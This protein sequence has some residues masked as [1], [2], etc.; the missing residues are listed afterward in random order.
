MQNRW[1]SYYDAAKDNPPRPTLL[2]A[3]DAWSG[4]PGFALDLGCGA[5]RDTLT[6]LA[7]G[8]RVHA[9]D[10]EQDAFAR[11]ERSVPAK[12][13]VRLTWALRQFEGIDLPKA[14]LA[15]ASFSLPFCHPGM[16][17]R[18][19]QSL[20]SALYPGG[21]FAGHLF[22]DRDSWSGRAE[23]TILSRLE[24]ARLL[25]GWDVIEL[26]ETEWDGETALGQPKHW[27]LFEIVARRPD[28]EGRLLEGCQ[29]DRP[30]RR[31]ATATPAD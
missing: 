17:P 2:M 12:E 25:E 28:R 18:L 19:W 24:V 4:S 26:R 3:L 31:W 11:L 8:W 14:N 9:I 16:F 21:I 29:G 5:G 1:P 7:R 22:G 15:N 10:V 6:L 30:V 23:M 20:V 13:R 27:H